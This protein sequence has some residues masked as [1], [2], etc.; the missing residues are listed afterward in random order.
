MNKIIYTAIDTNGKQQTCY[1]NAENNQ[2][3]LKSLKFKG[4][5][6]IILHQDASQTAI[7]DPYIDGMN[8]K[9]LENHASFILKAMEDR[10]LLF[11]LKENFKANSLLIIIGGII[12]FYAWTN[13]KYITVGIGL[14]LVFIM[15]LISMWRHKHVKRYD[16]ILTLHSY[17]K[18]DE[19]LIEISKHR[20][21]KKFPEHEHDLDFR[22][23]SILAKK[24][25]LNI[26][27]QL[28][29]K[30]K[31]SLDLKT[32]GYYDARLSDV[33]LSANDTVKGLELINRSYDMSLD[34][35]LPL[36]DLAITEARYGDTVKA[37]KLI[38]DVDFEVLPHFA[39]PY[40]DWI[41]GV[42]AKQNK[43]EIKAQTY[44]QKALKKLIGN[45]HLVQIIPSIVICTG[46]Y[47]VVLNRLGH[48][49]QARELVTGVLDVLQAHA[50]KYLL[51]ELSEINLT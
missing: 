7:K 10:S 34:K 45:Q 46:E 24:G 48:T 43:Q 13:E 47:A 31:T 1:I 26:G 8:Q 40:I 41:K 3:A 14:F 32:P 17:G 51:T 33:Y 12:V 44:L 5:S 30:W 21:F 20:K 28:V 9:E 27:Q 4:Y 35:T 39:H 36:L 37:I 50:D 25:Q 19:A 29:E 15:P 42:A 18:W 16:K 22:E 38:Q 23:A 49:N 2:Q 11:T 6:N